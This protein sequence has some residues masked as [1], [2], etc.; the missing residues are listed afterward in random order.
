MLICTDRRLFQYSLIGQAHDSTD[1]PRKKGGIFSDEKT[2]V[3]KSVF[4]SLWI[5]QWM[6]AVFL[7]LF[8]VHLLCLSKE[9]LDRLYILYLVFLFIERKI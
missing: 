9:N 5:L 4:S 2:A 1:C 7:L 6:H 8:N 3:L